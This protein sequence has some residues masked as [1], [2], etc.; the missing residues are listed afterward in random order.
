MEKA[1]YIGRVHL[2]A[3]VSIVWQDF[4]FADVLP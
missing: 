4:V 1:F 2:E 3:D